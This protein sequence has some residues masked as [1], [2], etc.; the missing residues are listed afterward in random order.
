MFHQVLQFAAL[1]FRETQRAARQLAGSGNEAEL[2]CRHIGSTLATAAN[3]VKVHRLLASKR[4]ATRASWVIVGPMKTV[5][6]F[7]VGANWLWVLA[8]T[9]AA[10]L[11][12]QPAAAPRNTH[13]LWEAR[14][15]S[16]SVY[17]LGSIHFAKDDI[18]PLAKPIEQAYER[19]SII[20]FEADLGEMKSMETQARLL[21]A[22]MSPAGKTLSQQVGK[23]TYSALQSWL[24]NSGGEPS[25]LDQMKPW[26]ASVSVVA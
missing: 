21:K 9:S 18:Y 15:K 14:G 23:E 17:L 26:R 7:H 24:K 16:N 1:S 4:L 8:L 22:G 20:V 25:M 19:S 2:C 3:G 13:P 10:Q 11:A 12:A 6:G 5:K